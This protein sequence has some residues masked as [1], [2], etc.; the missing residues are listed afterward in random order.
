MRSSFS[1]SKAGVV[2]TMVLFTG[3]NGYVARPLPLAASAKPDSCTA[4]EYQQFNFWIGD[5]DAFEGD[6]RV[7]RT[8][9]DRILDGCVLREDYE[10]TDGL[11][12]QSFNIYDASRKAWHQ[13]WVTNRGQV[14]VIE[15][16][17]QADAM[18]LAGSYVSARGE[19]TLVRGTWK[20]LNEGVRETAVTSIDGGTTWN[21][22]FDLVFRPRANA[23]SSDDARIV[24]DLDK[25]YQAAVQR[26]DAA[27]MARILGD[28]FIL[29]TGSGKTYTK[30]DLLEETRSRRV[31]YELQEDVEQT[32]R[33]WGDT[34][35]VTAKLS[36][37]GTEEGK[38]F[39]HTLWFSDTYVRTPAGWRYV[40]GQASLPLPGRKQ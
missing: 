4:P 26:N 14:L 34:A 36:E 39:N 15:G 8:R 7:A 28:D 37:K 35:V 40:L 20:P 22:W 12:G 16:K 23:S 17:L 29:V 11:K 18:V 32:V 5:W 30:S 10:G 13:S 21:P 2:A 3:W 33:N 31:H 9:V 19:Q 1:W 27:T 24:A 6:H 25:E 38:P